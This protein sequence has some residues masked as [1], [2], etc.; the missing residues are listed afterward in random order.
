MQ[1]VEQSFNPG[2]VLILTFNVRCSAVLFR[3]AVSTIGENHYPAT[4]LVFVYLSTLS[5]MASYHLLLRMYHYNSQRGVA[6]S[7][8]RSHC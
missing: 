2:L 4:A 6:I 8:E 1:K 5:L 3:N 7:F